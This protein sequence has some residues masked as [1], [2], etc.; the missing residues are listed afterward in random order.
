[1]HRETAGRSDRALLATAPVLQSPQFDQEF[2]IQTDASDT[3]IGAVL[4]QEIDSQ[5]CVLEFASRVLSPAEKNYSVTERNLHNPTG[6]LAR[7]ALCEAHTPS[8]GCMR[9]KSDR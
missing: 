2:V 4:L 9:G 7:W 8:H 6:R 5:E 1:M 3:G